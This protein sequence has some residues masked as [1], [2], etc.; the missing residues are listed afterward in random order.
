LKYIIVIVDGAADVSLEELGNKT[1]LEAARL[2]AMDRLAS[3]GIT[4]TVKNV[5]ADM[6]PGSDV[7]IMSLLGNNPH[8]Y[9]TGRAPIEAAAR[10]I[11]LEQDEWAFRCNL[12]TIIDGI[13]KDHSAGNISSDEAKALITE[14]NNNLSTK[15][16]KFYSGVSYR[17][18]MIFKGDFEGHTTPPHDI[19]DKEVKEYL[20]S[21]RGAKILQSLIK[22]SQT[23]LPDHEINRKRLRETKN[24]ATSIWFWGEG[25]PPVFESFKKKY[26]LDGAIIAAVDLVRGLGILMGWEVIDVPGI[27]GYI[28]TNYA[29]KGS[30]AIRALE[31]YDIIC[32]HIEAPDEA[33]HAGSP[34]EKVKAIEQIDMHIIGPLLNHFNTTGCEWRMLIMPDHPTP[35]TIRTHTKDPVPFIIAGSGIRWNGGKSFTEAEAAS[36]GLTI[37]QG[38]T[39]MDFFLSTNPGG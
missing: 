17:N 37:E 9:Y 19:L 25:K 18:L 38:Y 33:G 11:K 12:V 35:C 20:P 15:K 14:A 26:G 22:Q 21:G 1:P 30:F 34:H 4:G 27:T 39:L 6:P 13:M 10:G 8:K 5:P 28:D 36:T 29:G 23:F 31:K 7:A 24:P 3:K 32:V 16:I 2:P